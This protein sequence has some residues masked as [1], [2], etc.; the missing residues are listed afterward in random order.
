MTISSAIPSIG[1]YTYETIR[2][3]IIFGRLEPDEKLKLDTL[4]ERYHASVSTLREVLSRLASDGFVV[5]EGQRGFFVAPMSPEDLREIA[6]LRILLECHALKLSFE[7]G[8][9]D[10]E[11]KVV[12]AHHKLSRME[13]RMLA[14][15]TSIREEWKRYDWEFHQALILAC[16]SA[17]LLKVHGTVFDK[18]LRYQMRTLTFRGNAAAIEHRAFLDAALARDV[19]KAQTILRVH[20]RGG[21]EHS[22]ENPT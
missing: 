15:D 12:A 11:G 6:D 20:I 3:D 13:Q 5:A 2:T 9:T 18:Y 10:W 7:A 4:K 19:E 21:V 22:L 16:G 8:D 14:G 1:T 17:E